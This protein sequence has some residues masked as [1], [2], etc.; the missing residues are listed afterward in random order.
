MAG[1]PVDLLVFGDS[2]VKDDGYD[3]WAVLLA[4]H[5]GL[6]ALN[7]AEDDS[8]SADLA[9]QFSDVAARVSSGLELAPDCLALVHSGGN[10]LHFSSPVH[11]MAVAAA[12][13]V[14]SLGCGTCGMLP[15]L[16]H[17]M[18]TNVASL[19]RNLLSL[20]VRRVALVGVPLTSLMPYIP[21]AVSSLGVPGALTCCDSLMRASNAI[22]LH[23]LQMAMRSAEGRASGGPRL[24]FGI[25]IDEA[26]AIEAIMTR[27]AATDADAAGA[28]WKDKSHPS[29]AMHAALAAEVERQ[30]RNGLD[31]HERVGARIAAKPQV[32]DAHDTA[33]T[34]PLLRYQTPPMTSALEW[35]DQPVELEDYREVHSRAQPRARKPT[36]VLPLQCSRE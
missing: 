25:V 32:T 20:G 31:G 17:T 28:F 9:N 3:T 34:D 26:A 21:D 27:E 29:D 8:V 7:V 4:R 33:E 6:R 36:D 1:R 35:A 15:S 13:G 23:A 11:L 30:I 12:G 16:V 10:D 19:V 22:I 18:S 14:L 5:W 24:E 2:W